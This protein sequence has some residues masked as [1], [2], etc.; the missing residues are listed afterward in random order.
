MQYD[1]TSDIVDVCLQAAISPHMN[2]P[3]IPFIYT[4]PAE[5]FLDVVHQDE[6][7]LVLNKPC[8]LL[9]VPGKAE[10]HKDCLETRAQSLYPTATTIHRL[11]MDTSGLLVMAMNKEAHRHVGLQFEKRMTRKTYIARVWGHITEVHGEVDLPLRCDWPNRPKQMVDHELGR[12]ALTRWEVIEREAKTTL[13][14]LMPVTGRSHQLRVHMLAIGHPIVG[15]RFYAQGEALSF[16]DRLH[17]HAQTLELRHPVG[18]EY[19]T[20]TAPCPFLCL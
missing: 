11:D 8:G 6:Q 7:L 14:K 3:D 12:S 1:A 17:L 10:E 13:V 2:S 15:D 16:S 5:P 4:P 20:F 9:S 19:N 18:G